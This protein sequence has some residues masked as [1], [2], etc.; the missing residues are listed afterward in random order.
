MY[1]PVTAVEQVKLPL[2]LRRLMTK[3]TLAPIVNFKLRSF[4]RKH[5]SMNE[6]GPL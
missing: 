1:R 3:L 6:G 5:L 2:V 4:I